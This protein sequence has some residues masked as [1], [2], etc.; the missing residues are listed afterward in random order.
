MASRRTGT[1]RGLLEPSDFICFTASCRP[2]AGREPRSCGPMFNS[3]IFPRMARFGS[4]F[5]VC[6]GRDRIHTAARA[7]PLMTWASCRRASWQ[8]LLGPGRIGVGTGMQL[9]PTGC[10]ARWPPAGRLWID[11][12]AQS[13]MAAAC[14]ALQPGRSVVWSWR[15]HRAPFGGHLL[16]FSSGT[17]G[18]HVGAECLRAMASISAVAAFSRLRRLRT[19]EAQAVS[20]FPELDVAAVLAQVKR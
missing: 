7:G 10:A 19:V 5:L 13:G 6:G 8:G 3:S 1:R 16:P 14:K 11:E 17:Q 4:T 15:P 20:R 2:T 12:Q 18:D 9:H